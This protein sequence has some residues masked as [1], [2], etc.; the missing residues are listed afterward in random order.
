[1]ENKRLNYVDMTKGLAIVVVVFYHLIAPCGI[2]TIID[3][4]ADTV[5]LTFFFY[6][7]YFHKPGK[8]TL[9]Q[10]IILRAKNLMIP[11]LK[12]SLF[13][14]SAGSVVL[15]IRKE[16][17]I[18]EAF[19]CLRNFFIGC[20]WNRTIQDWFGWEYY[21]LGKRYFFLADFWFLISLMLASIVFLL[22]VDHVIKSKARSLTAVF[23]L[24][25]TTG[26]LREFKI[27]LPYNIQLIPFWT[28]VMLIGAFFG[29]NK[30][31]EMS[32]L[33][34]AKEIVLGI[35]SI[36]AGSAISMFKQPNLNNYRGTF[37]E[38]ESISMILCLA[39]SILLIWGG[40][41]IFKR[42]E[43]AGVRVK[44]LSWLGSHS[45]LIYIYHMFFA[46]IICQITG[47]SIFYDENPSLSVILESFLLFAVVLSLCISRYV[48]GD[49]L[50]KE[51]A[52]QT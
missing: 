37:P 21:K 29:H 11:F 6:S 17:T 39:A 7:G 51:K 31:F 33:T 1:M 13:F 26:I 35:I 8:K 10:S 19:L 41:I 12:Y 15:V 16:E 44:E 5:L 30:L 49:K 28:A 42:I 22:I 45:L 27:F 23:L 18:K 3:H 47:F 4:L 52:K 38:R 36:A 14:W 2:K 43:M 25:A 48:I 40:G 32:S 20:I 24:L 9:S 46:W 50:K 34:G